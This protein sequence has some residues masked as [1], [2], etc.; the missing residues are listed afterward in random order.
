MSFCRWL[1]DLLL[2][3]AFNWK[4]AISDDGGAAEMAQIFSLLA[5]VRESFSYFLNTPR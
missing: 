4:W 5:N 1:S 2:P 3:F